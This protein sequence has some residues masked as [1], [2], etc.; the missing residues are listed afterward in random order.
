MSNILGNQFVYAGLPCDVSDFSFCRGFHSFSTFTEVYHELFYFIMALRNNVSVKIQQQLLD[1]RQ[2]QD[3]S[4]VTT[5]MSRTDWEGHFKFMALLFSFIQQKDKTS[6][7]MQSKTAYV[8][9]SPR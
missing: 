9:T 7:H 3:A 1:F 6:S 4:R 2:H 8:F 5:Y